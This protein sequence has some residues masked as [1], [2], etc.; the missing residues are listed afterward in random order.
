MFQNFFKSLLKKMAAHKIISGTIA[1]VIIFA[2]FYING[3]L[4]KN[5]ASVRYVTAAAEKG[6]IISSVSG[7]GQISASNQ[8][9]IKPKAS[10]DLIYLGIQNGQTV[11]AGTLIAELDSTDAQKAV[12]DAEASLQSAQLNLEKTQGPAGAP[13]PKNEQDAID[14]LKKAYDDGF[15]AVSNAFLDLPAIMTGLNNMLFTAD[16][17]LNNQWPVDYFSD[18]VQAYNENAIQYKNETN[19]KYK[20][21]KKEY[22]QNFQDYNSTSRFS[23]T[24]AIEALITES[25]NTTK[26]ISEAIKSANNL[27]LFYE[28]Q[29]SLQGLKPQPVAD[30]DLTS[31]NNYTGKLN[32]HLTNLLNIQNTIKDDKDAI[33]NAGLDV[34]TQQLSLQ[35]QI[36]SLADAK[37]NLANYYVYAPFDGIVAK[38][39]V[40][41][42]DSVS[43]GTTLATIITKQLTA[44]IPLNEV[45]VAKI[46]IGQ[47][48]TL[49]FDAV[50]NLT[51]TGEVAEIDTIGTVS[52]G[53]VTYNAKIVFD[54]QDAR[55]KIGMS[56]NA[57]II[58]DVKQNTIV[59]ANSAV[60]Q[61]NG[62]SYVQVL[63]NGMPQIK[64]VETGLVNDTDTEIIS[65][66]SE[67]DLVIT[68]TI[69]GTAATTNSTT[70]SRT[71]TGGT[72]SS[73]RI[74]GLGGFGAGR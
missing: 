12:R 74:P 40:Q 69:T 11:K 10:G 70:Q 52:Q 56:V 1:I 4:N 27:I 13:V 5:S 55:V 73:V 66:I 6:T 2:G 22:D 7:S 65:G 32:S 19:T 16:K 8:V 24:A 28:N 20:T 64:D 68:Q 45:D 26:D 48:V 54:T 18:S 60:K 14:N 3:A 51:M 58:T 36:N 62:A 59:V 46:K 29:I 72:G 37:T 34:Q 50:D 47:K 15:S 39:D 43:S 71:S 31:L 53:V 35:Q 9:D 17:N 57:A 63:V 21:A 44:E 41:K 67:G 49:T 33:T 38:V 30:T 42:G 61:Q 23:D 25:Y